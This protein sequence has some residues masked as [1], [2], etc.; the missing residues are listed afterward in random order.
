M[1]GEEFMFEKMFTERVKLRYGPETEVWTRK[2]FDPEEYPHFQNGLEYYINGVPTGLGT[3]GG[4]VS[5]VDGSPLR[6]RNFVSSMPHILE[7]TLM[8]KSALEK[9]NSAL[10]RIEKL[11]RDK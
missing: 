5:R 11:L 2:N 3:I 6:D 4:N 10:E 9:I 8:L 1:E 7:Q